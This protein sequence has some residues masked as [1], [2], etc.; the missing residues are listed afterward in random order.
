MYTQPR[1]MTVLDFQP[2]HFPARRDPFQQ[3]EHGVLISYISQ[4]S[5]PKEKT[6]LEL[7]NTHN[8]S[9]VLPSTPDQTKSSS[10][11]ASATAF[12]KLYNTWGTSTATRTGKPAR[13][14]YVAGT[15]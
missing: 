10:R 9:R 2:V 4:A 13:G 12:L 15:G 1:K 8:S 7:L 5:M 11:L 6:V 3:R 14:R